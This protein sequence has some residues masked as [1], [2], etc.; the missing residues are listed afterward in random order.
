MIRDEKNEHMTFLEEVYKSCAKKNGKM[1]S[2]E[3]FGAANC[4]KYTQMCNEGYGYTF[5][6][7]FST[8]AT[9]KET[10]TYKFEGL[11]LLKPI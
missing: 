11:E 5:F 10:V 4:Y 3:S 7:N 1:D 6:E 2:Y 8:E 9:I